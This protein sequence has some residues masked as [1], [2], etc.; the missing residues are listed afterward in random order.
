MCGVVINGLFKIIPKY[1]MVTNKRANS[2][3]SKLSLMLKKG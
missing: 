2:V 3:P 1:I